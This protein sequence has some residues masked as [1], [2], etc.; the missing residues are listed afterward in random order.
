[1]ILKYI[2]LDKYYICAR[3]VYLCKQHSCGDEKLV[4]R[5]VINLALA[6]V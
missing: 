5:D 2:H 1:M 4:I 6:C 3:F